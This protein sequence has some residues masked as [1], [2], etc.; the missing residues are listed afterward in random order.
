MSAS[1]PPADS[2]AA[3]PTGRAPEEGA[4]DVARLAATPEF[5]ALHASR[6]RF[7]VTGTLIVT[8]ALLIVFG[9]YGFAPD[10]M[11]EA[12]VGSLTWALL[13]GLALVALT[14]V[15][16]YAYVRKSR[17]WESLAERVIA[18]AERAPAKTGGRFAR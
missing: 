12:A 17:Q 4:I 13:L 16:A 11:G 18:Q 15:M 10:A 5:K 6:R 9:L 3:E 1:T 7:T 2:V 14:F 8:A